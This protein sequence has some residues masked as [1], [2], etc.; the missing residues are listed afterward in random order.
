MYELLVKNGKIVTADSVE[1]GNIAVKDGKLSLSMK[2]LEE[3]KEEHA[4]KV[5]IPK[6]ENIGTNLSDLFKNIK[7]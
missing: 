2:A 6:S 7:L 1:D 5:V 3:A 4:E